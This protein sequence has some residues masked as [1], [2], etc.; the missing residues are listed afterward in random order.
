MNL[1]I[2]DTITLSYTHQVKELLGKEESNRGFHVYTT[3]LM[4][5]EQGNNRI[6]RDNDTGP[7]TT[8]FNQNFGYNPVI[9][10]NLDAIKEF[11]SEESK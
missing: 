4:D 1:A 7:P 6:N 8:S 9:D 10:N 3:M 5:A 2:K 11:I